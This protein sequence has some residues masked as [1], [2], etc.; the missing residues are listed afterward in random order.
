MIWRMAAPTRTRAA[1][2]SPADR[3]E[4]L[5]PV[6]E[7]L[8]VSRGYTALS[9][10]E[11]A[12]AA[13]VTR[14]VIYDQFGSKEGAF[15]ACVRRARD[16]FEAELRRQVGGHTSLRDQIQAGG[17]HLFT[18]LERD[19]SRWQL[20]FAANAVFP[21]ELNREL[22][23]LRFDTIEQIRLIL[24]AGAPRAPEQRIEAC[25]H[26]LSGAGERLGQWWLSRP[27]IPKATIVEHFVEIVW[28]GL[29][30]YVDR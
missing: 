8:F 29:G 17:E 28:T 22:A 4:Q 12:R 1:R 3:R 19:P 6:I 25:A 7:E 24:A 27:D 5:L 10:E 21:G 9:M 15:L 23:Q 26:A 16:E 18:T 13:G 20:L 2:M 11:L 30:P 14:P